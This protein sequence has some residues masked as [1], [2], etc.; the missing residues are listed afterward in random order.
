MFAFYIYHQALNL[1]RMSVFVFTRSIHRFCMI[2][3]PFSELTSCQALFS[4]NEDISSLSSIHKLHLISLQN[5]KIVDTDHICICF[6]Q[7]QESIWLSNFSLTSTKYYKQIQVLLILFDYFL[8][9]IIITFL[10]SRFVT[11]VVFT[12]QLFPCLQL[13]CFNYLQYL[14]SKVNNQFR[15]FLN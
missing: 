11:S 8:V 4:A 6:S 12:L 15:S 10:Y 3:F 13:C 7:H 9:D 2:F 14:Q 1:S 5:H